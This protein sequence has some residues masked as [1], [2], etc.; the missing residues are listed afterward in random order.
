M[1][2][3]ILPCGMK[4][5][6]QITTLAR[7]SGCLREA[8]PAEAGFSAQARR[9]PP[10]NDLF[11]KLFCNKYNT[12]E[13][14]I[15]ATKLGLGLVPDEVSGRGLSLPTGRQGLTPSGTSCPSQRRGL[16]PPSRSRVLSGRGGRE[17]AQDFQRCTMA[18]SQ[19]MVRGK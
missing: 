16:W 10:L 6:Y 4:Q 11:L 17:F 2:G 8:A 5:S 12:L 19:G 15:Q 13:F 9:L 7:H 14:R 18:T 3:R 1:S